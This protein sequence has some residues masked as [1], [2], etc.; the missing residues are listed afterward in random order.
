MDNILDR[1]IC[2]SPF[3]YLEIHNN[4][5]YG[6]CPT[7]LPIVYGKTA[8]LAGVWNGDVANKVRESVS[9]GS[10]RYC[11]KT[12]CPYLSR[13]I[14]ESDSTGFAEKSLVKQLTHNTGPT[15][16]NFSF[17]RS[18]N[19]SCESCRT[20]VIMSNKIE[21]EFTEKTIKAVTELY[22]DS[23]RT[24]YL[25]GN[26]DPFASK[27]F[28]NFLINFDRTKFPNISNI[29][30]HTNALLL[31][32]ELWDELA[33]IY[34]LLNTIEIS[35][36]AATKETYEK[37]R[38]GGNWETLLTNLEF[39]STLKLRD[40]RVSFVVQDTNYLEMRDFH[41]MIM[42]IFKNKATTYFNKISN[43][44]TYSEEQYLKK[45]IWSES[46]PQF[47][48][49]LEQLHKITKIY[50]C[51]HNMYDIIETHSIKPTIRGLI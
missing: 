28:R 14:N 31:T 16:V 17:D 32:K 6:C 36:D 19:L 20:S 22:G 49:F 2:H 24:I 21:V 25:C 12:E 26:A 40:V 8:E 46:H 7:W 33:P 27:S 15:T 23:I 18:C 35:V 42:K 41:D 38:R 37:V 44:G 5:V 45:Q 43:W 29:H 4:D 50:N 13:L 30:L 11:S 9:D 48:S 10:Y 47:N 51:R 39:I 1:Y 3:N 34:N